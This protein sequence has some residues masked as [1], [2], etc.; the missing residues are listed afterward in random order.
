M[1]DAG[2]DNDGY[3]DGVDTAYFGG[4]GG[5]GVNGSGF[6]TSG[7]RSV[8]PEQ[9]TGY[10][11]PFTDDEPDDAA[12]DYDA[13]RYGDDDRP[14]GRHNAVPGTRRVHDLGVVKADSDRRARRKRGTKP[15]AAASPAK[16]PSATA[17]GQ[18]AWL[19]GLSAGYGVMVF[20]IAAI[21]MVV[22]MIMVNR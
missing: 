12:A 5:P 11:A 9:P 21:V 17:D 1:Y 18:P 6:H 14:R 8:P 15:K 3:Q 10:F 19:A 16:V 7:F 22:V 20:A 4:V 13:A 2:R